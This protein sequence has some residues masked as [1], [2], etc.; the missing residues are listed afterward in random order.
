MMM[1]VVFLEGLGSVK[2]DEGCF[3]RRIRFRNWVN[4]DALSRIFSPLPEQFQVYLF[5]I[6][7]QILFS[8]YF[9][10]FIIALRTRFVCR[11]RNRFVFVCVSL[12]IR[13]IFSIEAIY[14]SLVS[15]EIIC[16]TVHK[17]THPEH[18]AI[19]KYFI[20]YSVFLSSQKNLF[21][22]WICMTIPYQ[23][24]GWLC[25]FNRIFKMML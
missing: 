11:E 24:F 10:H 14:P 23:G 7:W 18:A 1:R 25:N 2:N 3:S 17:M 19:N 12:Y 16:T 15:W 13:N 22:H 6:L 5:V 8:Y 20:L 9:F 4:L 21:V